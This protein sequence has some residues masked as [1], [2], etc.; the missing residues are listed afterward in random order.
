MDHT[1][2]NRRLTAKPAMAPG[3]PG[4]PIFG[5]LRD[6]T[7]AGRLEYFVQAWHRYGD[8]VRFQMGPMP[9]HLLVH[10]E[11]VRHVLVSH[12]ANYPKGRGYDRLR[13][14]LGT[15]L[16]TSE[17]ELWRRQ[18]RLMQPPFRPQDVLAFAEDIIAAISGLLKRWEMWARPGVYVD[19]NEE[20]MRLAMNI[21]GQ[22]MFGFSVGEEARDAARAFN[23]MLQFVGKRSTSLFEFPLSWPTPSNRRVHEAMRAV[24][25]FMERI[26]TARRNQP[27]AQRDLLSILLR[28]RDEESGEGMD[29][30]QLR[31][32]VLTIFF[33]GHE[34]TAQLLT[35]TWYLLS[36][37]PH[38]R[39]RL[40]E[41]VD[42]V[43]AGRPPTV[44][45]LPKLP[46]TRMVI[47]EALRLYP[48]V[49]GYVRDARDDDIIDGYHIP[50]GSMVIVTPYITHRHPDFW[51]N[52]EAFEPERFSPE[53]SQGRH[54][55]SY[56]PFGAGQR[57]CLGNNFALLEAHLVIAAVAQLYRLNVR[58]GYR[59]IPQAVTSLRPHAGMPMSI[60][61][62]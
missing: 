59:P 44:S 40:E 12:A 53:R 37:H 1:D 9:M 61:R 26:I 39:A 6:S 32:E 10:P 41:E 38:V 47:D 16:F 34:T 33:A 55:Y 5:N 4:S 21:I 45:D 51:H 20:M 60:E 58:P 17:G 29:E 11:H 19:I 7:G 48:P 43:L 2:S 22:T 24:N 54:R 13:V 23:D 57:I 42:R 15:G 14:F 25:A 49:W 31:Y 50:G 27:Q 52:P 56:F 62:R 35:W 36:T 28:A 18:R 8:I 3:P 46:F 30:Q